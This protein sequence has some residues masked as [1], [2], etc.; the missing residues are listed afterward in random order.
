MYLAGLVADETK[1]SK[2]DL[3]HWAENA[4]WSMISEYT[5]PWIATESSYGWELASE[6]IKS[7]KE[8][9]ASAGWATF[10]NLV[11]YVRDEN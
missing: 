7:D 9:I 10:A 6:W 2:A 1:M 4:T 5:V 11:A 3:Q 8:N